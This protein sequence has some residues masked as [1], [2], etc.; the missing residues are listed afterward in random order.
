MRAA[1]PWRAAQF[2]GIPRSGLK[3]QAAIYRAVLTE[4]V[5]FAICLVTAPINAH[6][7]TV[8]AVAKI[9]SATTAVNVKSATQYAVMTVVA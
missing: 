3:F 1:R 5:K 2:T 7:P 9:K 8:T 4:P 6:A